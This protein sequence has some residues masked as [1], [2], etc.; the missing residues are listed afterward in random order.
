[1]ETRFAARHSPMTKC[2]HEH[3]HQA[4]QL[5]PITHLARHRP[6]SA[7]AAG[8]PWRAQLKGRT[9]PVHPGPLLWV[10]RYRGDVRCDAE[11]GSQFGTLAATLA[12]SS[13][14]LGRSS[15]SSLI[16]STNQTVVQQPRGAALG[17]RPAQRTQHECGDVVDV[18]QI[19]RWRA[20]RRCRPC[21]RDRPAPGES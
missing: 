15:S 1:M 9:E 8:W 7:P 16:K 12:V 21:A 6:R 13:G 14:L 4:L 19:S 3:G 17:H 20:A 18:V 10:I 2:I 11:S 5:W